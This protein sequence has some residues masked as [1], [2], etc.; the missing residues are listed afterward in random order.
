LSSLFVVSN[1]LRLRFFKPE[2][3]MEEPPAACPVDFESDSENESKA[4]ESGQSVLMRIDGMTCI[5]CQKHVEQALNAI[6]GVF[7][8]ADW[9]A[10]TAQILVKNG[11]DDETLK[12][13][14]ENE[15]YDVISVR[16]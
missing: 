1:A 9:E 3:G 5:N 8:K 10:G 11:A 13:A 15:G 12:Q 16:R 4:S 2:F 6:P 14:V 7:A